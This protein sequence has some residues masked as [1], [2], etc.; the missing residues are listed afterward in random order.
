MD[1][2]AEAL[3]C[4]ELFLHAL[5][6]NNVRIHGHTQGKHE[7]RDTRQGKHCTECCKYAEEEHHVG[8]K[9]DVG[10]NTCAL[11]EEDHIDQHK[12]E[13]DEEGDETCAD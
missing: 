7:T 5:I 8:E 4:L 13:G 1:S 10:C 12:D 6:Y 11:V 3:A 9:C 2:L